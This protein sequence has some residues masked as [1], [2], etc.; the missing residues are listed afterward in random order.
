MSQVHA[1][2]AHSA[3][4]H[5]RESTP[6]PPTKK[7]KQEVFIGWLVGLALIFALVS[8]V[9]NLGL[10]N[11][12]LKVEMTDHWKGAG[13]TP[14]MQPARLPCTV[15]PDTPGCAIPA[16]QPIA[17]PAPLRPAAATG[18][19]LRCPRCGTCRDLRC[20]RCGG[21]LSPDSRSNYPG[22]GNTG[23]FYVCPAG[24][25]IPAA[26]VSSACPRCGSPMIIDTRSEAAGLAA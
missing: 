9:T 20:P 8:I 15:A 14:G 1:R 23:G 18:T 17:N 2:A 10:G 3:P 25:A 24:H 7:R 16:F 11:K 4:I 5:T 26:R 6:L 21:A 22:Y 13:N 19:S 12:L